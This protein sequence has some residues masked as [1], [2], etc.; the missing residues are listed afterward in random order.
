MI[1]R[2]LFDGRKIPVIGLGTWGIG[3]GSQAD[4]SQDEDFI[5]ILKDALKIG[6]THIDTAEVYASGHCEE[7]VGRAIQGLNR[8]DLFITTKI[9][10]A[11]LRREEA[12]KAIDGSLRRLNTDFVDLYLIH[13]PSET[14]PLEE[15][16][17]ALNKMVEQKKVRYLGVSNFDLEQLKKARSLSGT[18]IIAN[19]V[20]Y[21][22]ND[23]KYVNN[24]VLNYC[25]KEGILF[26]AY[27]P[28]KKS[29]LQNGTVEKI[30]KKHGA[31]GAQIVL[32]WLSQQ[33]MVITIPKS[34]D[35]K[36]LQDNFQASDIPLSSIDMN[37]LDKL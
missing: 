18:P 35:I 9:D 1:H 16:F 5:H 36:H 30:A 20:P 26:T 10:P 29:D 15:S 22:L 17:E 12:H 19:Q 23:K 4:N 7:L 27:S 13:W 11:H 25:Q 34:T 28:I 33:D 24:G 2:E 14:I 32:A 31:T 37:E 8:D 6:Y 3:G 21:G